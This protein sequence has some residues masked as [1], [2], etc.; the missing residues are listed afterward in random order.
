MK[1]F[2]YYAFHSFIN[3]VRK[4]LKSWVIIFILVCGLGGGLIGVMAGSTASKI[5][6][7]QTRQETQNPEKINAEKPTDTIEQMVKASGLEKQELVCL[8]MTVATIIILLYFLGSADGGGKIFL[9]AD[10]TLLFSSPLR[11]QSVLIFR[12]FVQMAV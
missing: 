9:P 10:V 3:Q 12:L 8:G 6:E 2:G 4:L 7:N 1:L 11:P 5:E